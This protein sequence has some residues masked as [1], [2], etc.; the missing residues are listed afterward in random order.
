MDQEDVPIDV[1]SAVTAVRREVKKRKMEE[2]RESWHREVT[3]GKSLQDD[4]LTRREAVLVHQVRTGKTPIARAYLHSIGKEASPMCQTCSE[5]VEDV[6]HLF[7][8][9]LLGW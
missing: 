7:L 5:A 4:D 6:R 9:G 2:S 1:E 3:G 8:Y